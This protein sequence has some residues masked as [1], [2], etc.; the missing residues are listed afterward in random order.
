[1]LAWPWAQGYRIGEGEGGE[2]GGEGGAGLAMGPG[3]RVGEG[4]EAGLAI[5]PGLLIEGVVLAWPL[6]QGYH[7][8]R[9]RS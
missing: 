1:M 4:G 3:L 5:G 2:G 6:A 9:R 7:W 8:R